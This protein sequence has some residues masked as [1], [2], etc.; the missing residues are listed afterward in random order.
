MQNP[1]SVE[2][3]LRTI[4][5]DIA[6]TAAMTQYLK[7]RLSEG[8]EL[9][10]RMLWDSSA[11]TLGLVTRPSP[12]PGVSPDLTPE[13]S[14]PTENP[15]DS[16]RLLIDGIVNACEEWW[17]ESQSSGLPHIS[18]IR[19][20]S[21]YLRSTL[22]WHLPSGLTRAGNLGPASPSAADRPAVS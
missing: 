15:G 10:S 19:Y 17:L 20:F 5:N 21:S 11:P 22:R 1:S 6:R 8:L 9:V 16:S 7:Q 18:T 13:P 2:T 4:E 14:A 3:R 12:L